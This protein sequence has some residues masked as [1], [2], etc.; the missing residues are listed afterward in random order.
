MP[1]TNALVLGFPKVRLYSVGAAPLLLAELTDVEVSVTT[2]MKEL[3]NSA[4]VPVSH[5]ITGQKLT[6]KAKS[7]VVQIGAQS[8][9]T[10]GA[11]SAGSIVTVENE[12]LT[13]SGAGPYTATVAHAATFGR[14]LGVVDS[15]GVALV[16][17]T[18]T[19][20][21]GQYSVSSVGVYTASTNLAGAKAT[22]TYLDSTTGSTSTMSNIPQSEATAYGLVG[23]VTMNG[24]TVHIEVPSVVFTKG[25]FAISSQTQTEPDIEF[26]G[27]AASG[28]TVYALSI[29]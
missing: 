5:V 8:V 2:T 1:D 19:P 12:A 17:T 10:G 22:Y 7:M 16:P 11:T 9:A 21:A 13:F 15:T 6:G 29:R 4:R 27:Q 20:G 24:H 25:G 23:D 18:G 28:A 14:D 26:A 3:V